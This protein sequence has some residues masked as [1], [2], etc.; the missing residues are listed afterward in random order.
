MQY[1]DNSGNTVEGNFIGTNLAGN[2][3]VG[4][5]GQPLGNGSFGVLIYRGTTTPSAVPM[6]AKATSSPAIRA[7]ALG[8]KSHRLRTTW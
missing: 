3:I 2:A 8:S 6:Q 5:D 7:L 1:P 4:P